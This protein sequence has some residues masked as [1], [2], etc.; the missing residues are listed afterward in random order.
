MDVFH[1]PRRGWGG[2]G[3]REPNSDEGFKPDS[4]QKLLSKLYTVMV[5][6]PIDTCR[7]L[8]C[9]FANSDIPKYNLVLD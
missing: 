1:N 9:I 2:G 7:I 6:A 4:T 8:Q 5:L 3:G